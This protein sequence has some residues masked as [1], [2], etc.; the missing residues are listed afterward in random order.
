MDEIWS[1]LCMHTI[2]TEF[3]LDQLWTCPENAFHQFELSETPVAL[4]F[5][6]VIETSKKAKS[7]TKAII[8][9][10]LKG[11]I[12]IISDKRPTIRS[13]MA[14]LWQFIIR[15]HDFHIRKHTHTHTHT[16]N[17]HCLEIVMLQETCKCISTFFNIDAHKAYR[18]LL[19]H[20]SK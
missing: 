1:F 5:I 18:Y 14:R 19:N 15:L 2:T 12:Y 8:I 3:A 20:T 16:H 17:T 6:M 11:A 4:M 10:S 13:G 9:P 7:S